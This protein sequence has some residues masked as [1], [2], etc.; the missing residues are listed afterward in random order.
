MRCPAWTRPVL[1][2]RTPERRGAGCSVLKLGVPQGL[3]GFRTRVLGVAVGN[4]AARAGRP[5]KGWQLLFLLYRLE[6]PQ[7][8]QWETSPGPFG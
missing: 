5:E 4:L 8:L 3:Q 7:Q 6:P 1:P 2:G